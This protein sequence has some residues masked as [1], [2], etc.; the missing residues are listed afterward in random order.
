MSENTAR[1]RWWW[2]FRP[3]WYP[4]VDD[5]A[6]LTP[7]A[8]M[9]LRRATS[10]RIERTVLTLLGFG[11]YCVVALESPDSLLLLENPSVSLPFV[12][13]EI[14]FTAFLIVGPLLLLGIW[15]YLH[16]AVTHRRLEMAALKQHALA[17]SPDLSEGRHP[18]LKVVGGLTYLGLAPL[19]MLDFAQGS[20]RSGLRRVDDA[21]SLDRDLDAPPRCHSHAEFATIPTRTEHRRLRSTDHPDGDVLDRPGS[22]RATLRP[23]SSGARRR[24]SPGVNLRGA[25]AARANFEGAILIEADLTG[26]NLGNARMAG[27]DLT[28]ATVTGA[29]LK[30]TDLKKADPLEGELQPLAFPPRRSRDANLNSANLSFANISGVDWERAVLDY[31]RLDFADIENSNFRG[32]SLRETSFKA[33]GTTARIWPVLRSRLPRASH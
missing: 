10:A 24:L 20:S 29:L 33:C 16:L 23:L 28:G 9:A 6:Q 12:Q 21:G 15:T 5:I 7:D 14:S 18:F 27:A 26:I 4:T 1:L 25:Y 2:S 13:T 19:V 22:D 11:A 30:W 17:I 31:G 3:R 32:A 8:L